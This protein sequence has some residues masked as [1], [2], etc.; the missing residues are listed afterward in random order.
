M[1][2]IISGASRSG[3]SLITKI[4]FKKL[5]IPYLSIDFLMMGFMHGIPSFGINDKMWAHEIGEKLWP[6]LNGMIETM[7]YNNQDYIFEGEA[8]IPKYIAELENKFPGKIKACFLGYTKINMHEKI[9]H[10][11][12]YPNHD[13]DWLVNLEESQIEEHIKNMQWYSQ[14]IEKECLENKI[15]YF[16][17]SI[18]F[19]GSMERVLNYLS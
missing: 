10:V 17:S 16:D 9:M 1:I 12:K 3:K 4:L 5:S 14:K 11:K 15:E 6:I 8:F 19:E 7:I 18:G 2:Y 13:H